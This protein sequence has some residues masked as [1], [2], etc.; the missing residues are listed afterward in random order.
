[1]DVLDILLKPLLVNF[2]VCHRCNQ[3]ELQ[4]SFLCMSCGKWHCD[5]C[6][7]PREGHCVSCER[8]ASIRLVRP[9]MNISCE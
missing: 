2:D 3:V 6:E 4:D 9:Y 7:S 1:M 8:K 5:D